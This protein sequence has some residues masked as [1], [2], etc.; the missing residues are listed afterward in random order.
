[1]VDLQLIEQ[2]PNKNIYATDDP[3]ML[4]VE[5]TGPYAAFHNN[6]SCFLFEGL[7]DEVT[8]HYVGQV[9]QTEMDVVKL[10]NIPITFTVDGGVAP[11]I[12][13]TK[14][15]VGED[16][17]VTREEILDCGLLTEDALENMEETSL[18][19]NEVLY[20]LFSEKGIIL[21]NIS[22]T[23][24]Y[25]AE[26]FVVLAGELTTETMCLLD[27]ETGLRLDPKTMDNAYNIILER[28][29]G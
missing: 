8:C 24:G 11:E 9:S 3:Q 6:L 12:T 20:D 23:Y 25:I 27:P 29:N 26:H 13:Y 18:H 28:M 16:V 22:F 10:R 15:D 17:F 1:M 19:V 4:R 7:R 21:A 14:T 2:L 5:F